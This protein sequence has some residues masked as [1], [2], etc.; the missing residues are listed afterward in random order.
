IVSDRLEDVIIADEALRRL[1]ET[2]MRKSQAVELIYFGGL[3]YSEAAAVLDIS[4]ATLHRDLAF[5]RSWLRRELASS[6][7]QA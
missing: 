5:A 7:Q 3:S 6:D 4:E 1:A 2:Y